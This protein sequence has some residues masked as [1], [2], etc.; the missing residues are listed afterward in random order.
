MIQEQIQ[1]SMGKSSQQTRELAR[2][3]GKL[4]QAQA[5]LGWA[6]ILVVLALTGAIYLRQTSRI[7]IVGRSAQGLQQELGSLKQENSELEKEIAEQQRLDR[8]QTKAIELGFVTAQ[9]ENIDYLVVPDYPA[10][11]PQQ[12]IAGPNLEKQRPKPMET[13]SQA[14]G[15]ALQSSLR[16]LI[17]GESSE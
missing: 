10:S 1:R 4:T 17:E 14:L 7:A 6:V 16:D 3:L 8:L 13:M 12:A 5:A 15:F 9:A 11:E 2:R